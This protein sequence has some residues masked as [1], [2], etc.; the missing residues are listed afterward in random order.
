MY[1]LVAGIRALCVSCH[2]TSIYNT[3]WTVSIM[4]E[5]SISREAFRRLFGRTTEPKLFEVRRLAA[6]YMEGTWVEVV[7]VLKS[8]AERAALETTWA[9][10]AGEV[11]QVLST[12]EQGDTLEAFEI[13]TRLDWLAER[14]ERGAVDGEFW[15]AH[16]QMA[17]KLAVHFVSDMGLSQ[18]VRAEL[19]GGLR[20]LFLRAQQY[21]QAGGVARSVGN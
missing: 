17:A 2:Q 6:I 16:L 5:F 12:L 15:T 13:A 18:V 20:E 10:V 8:M 1:F 4:G 14:V 11:Y 7:G 21:A 3:V 19:H 9:E